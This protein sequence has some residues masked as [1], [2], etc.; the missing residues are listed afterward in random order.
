MCMTSIILALGLGP[1]EYRWLGRVFLFVCF[2]LF[3]ER[4]LSQADKA[5]S[6][7]RRHMASSVASAMRCTCTLLSV[8]SCSAKFQR[9]N[10]KLWDQTYDTLT[11]SSLHLFCFSKS[12][13]VLLVSYTIYRIKCSGIPNSL[14]GKAHLPLNSPPLII[15]EIS[16]LLHCS[17]RHLH[18]THQIL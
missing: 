17:G 2:V 11:E 3:T 8:L 1:G 15:I 18:K 12:L 10:L 9:F 7:R 16:C 13:A 5:G 14:K 6:N 4:P